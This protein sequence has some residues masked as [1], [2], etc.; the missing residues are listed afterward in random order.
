MTLRPDLMVYSGLTT[1]IV[2]LSANLPNLPIKQ[3]DVI[4]EVKEL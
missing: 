4:I 3:T 1:D 2:E